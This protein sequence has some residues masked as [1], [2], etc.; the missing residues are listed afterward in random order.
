[1]GDD[2][3][4]GVTWVDGMEVSAASLNSFLADAALKAT[5]ISAKTLKDPLTNAVEFMV[6]DAGVIKKAT[7]Q[8]VSA[9]L[10]PAGTIIQ[11]RTSVSSAVDSTAV[12]IPMDNT[13]PQN[14]EGKEYITLNFTPLFSNS[15][16]RLRLIAVVAHSSVSAGGITCALFRD[17]VADAI[18]AGPSILGVP[19][20]IGQLILDK[21]DAPATTAQ[22][23]Y[24]MRFGPNGGFTAFINR[25]NASAA[26]YGGTMFTSL[27]AIEIKQ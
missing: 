27:E 20:F 24:K 17:A 13:K 3:Q 9:L 12:V 4:P 21:D 2:I 11:R 10:L 23:T 6:N 19:D 25:Y 5:S 26:L 15:I 16:I 7:F 14:T 1:M 18:V 22:V 8:Q